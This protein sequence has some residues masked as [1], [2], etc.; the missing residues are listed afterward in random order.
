[1]PEQLYTVT[2][3]CISCDQE[4]SFRHAVSDDIWPN[5]FELQCQNPEC[6]Q[7]QDVPFRKCTVEP[8]TLPATRD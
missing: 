7:E 1:M 6:G 3:G 2:W 4:H 8:F 5:K